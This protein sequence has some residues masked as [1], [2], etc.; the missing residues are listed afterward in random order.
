MHVSRI[1]SDLVRIRSENPPGKTRDII[2]YIREFLSQ[3]GIRSTVHGDTGGMCN[4]LA[5][6]AGDKLSL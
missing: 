5:P 2:E 1:C 4:L 6:G 3:L